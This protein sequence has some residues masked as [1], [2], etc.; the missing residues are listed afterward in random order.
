MPPRRRARLLVRRLVMVG[1]DG[2]QPGALLHPASGGAE[3]VAADGLAPVGCVLATA[4]SGP[5]TR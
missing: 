3:W 2:G 1:G 5:V 4:I